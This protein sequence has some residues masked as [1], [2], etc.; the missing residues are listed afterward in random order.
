MT[1]RAA[2]FARDFF[3]QSY[4]ATMLEDVQ[5][6][7][8]DEA[9]SEDREPRDCGTIYTVPDG[10]FDQMRADAERFQREAANDLTAA[11]DM[12]VLYGRDQ[13]G[14]DFYLT[15][16][17]HGVGFWDR[18]IGEAG[19]R[20]TARVGHGTAFPSFDPYIGDDGAVYLA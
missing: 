7:E 19:E 10:T 16:V 5:A 12:G 15:R 20:L 18:G 8:N 2:L 14:A 13:A 17:G 4:I 1:D 3:L 9:C 6:R 11:H